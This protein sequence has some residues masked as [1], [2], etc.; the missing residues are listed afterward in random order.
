MG[1]RKKILIVSDY[2]EPGFRFGGPIKTLKNIIASLHKSYDFYIITRNR[3]LGINKPF[4][5]PIGE[6][7]SRDD[8]NII[9]YPD[10]R[11]T[12]SVIRSEIGNL[13]P[14]IVY[15]NSFFSWRGSIQIILDKA[16]SYHSR[17]LLAPRG[18]FSPGALK[19]KS[20]KKDVYLI[21]ARVLGLYR[22][23]IFHASS[24]QEANYIRSHV[25]CKEILVAPDLAEN[26]TSLV[27]K[28]KFPGKLSLCF[29][30]RIAPKKN[31]LYAIEAVG[32]LLSKG[33]DITLDIFGPVE[34][35]GYWSACEALIRDKRAEK[36]MRYCGELQPQDVRPTFGKYDFF[37]FPT[38]GENF[39]HVVFESL[40]VGT[41]VIL[42]NTTYWSDN[43]GLTDWGFVFD[44]RQPE[45]IAQILESCIGMD[46]EE[47]SKLRTGALNKAV[48]FVGE[49]S[50]VEQTK[51]IFDKIADGRV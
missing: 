2:F 19:I 46:E 24:T 25:N 22:N 50:L 14:E 17:V 18:E 31:L 21:L 47:Y 28:R 12:S 49:A 16:V 1:E 35:K 40:S 43:N 15:L 13:K 9:Y 36:F 33:H 44:L 48:N 38:E 8:Y 7:L 4:D 39:G 42:S 37:F 26:I 32:N 29:V 45:D 20:V 11:L 34:D 6:W 30:S 3:D 23:V 51:S 10:K 27:E 5:L 41:P